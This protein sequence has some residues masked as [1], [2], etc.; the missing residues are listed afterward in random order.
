MCSHRN[1]AKSPNCCERNRRKC[2]KR[3]A[4]V[5]PRWNLRGNA[6]NNSEPVSLRLNQRPTN[7]HVLQLLRAWRPP[8]TMSRSSCIDS[9]PRLAVSRT[10][11][12]NCGGQPLKGGFSG[13][14]QPPILRS[15]GSQEDLVRRSTEEFPCC[16][17][18]QI[19]PVNI[20]RRSRNG[21]G[22][23]LPGAANRYADGACLSWCDFSSGR[24]ALWME[25]IESRVLLHTT[26]CEPAHLVGAPQRCSQRITHQ[27]SRQSLLRAGLNRYSFSSDCRPTSWH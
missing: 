11:Q 18:F 3:L 25:K 23:P 4:G 22:N 14:N 6:A 13:D 26:M 16:H 19:P 27:L 15:Q 1:S 12:I 21:R 20:A 17:T 7:V 24:T 10:G 9:S 2:C 8:E 5:R